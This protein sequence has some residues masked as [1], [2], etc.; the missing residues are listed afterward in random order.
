MV[1]ASDDYYY[2]YYYTVT[3]AGWD[4]KTTIHGIK[5]GQDVSSRRTIVHHS[6]GHRIGRNVLVN[7]Q[8]LLI[9]QK[10][11]HRFRTRRAHDNTII[12]VYN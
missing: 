10:E 11:P 7:T 12:L 1:H 4:G 2:Y 6:Y 8:V 9:I 3:A 5:N